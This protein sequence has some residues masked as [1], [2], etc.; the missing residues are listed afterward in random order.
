ML[1]GSQ[2]EGDLGP[3]GSWSPLG[4]GGRCEGWGLVLSFTRFSQETCFY[5]FTASERQ[6]Y[7]TN[8]TST[9]P[10]TIPPTVPPT[11]PSTISW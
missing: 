9:S 5:W 7:S 2:P 11:V 6:I 1:Q 8:P 10:S 3:Q 4:M